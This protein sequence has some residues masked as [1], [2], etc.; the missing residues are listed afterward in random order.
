M[1]CYTP[2][3]EVSHVNQVPPRIITFG[4][5]GT[6]RGVSNPHRWLPSLNVAIPR[7]SVFCT[8]RHYRSVGAETP[9]LTSISTAHPMTA[10][11]TALGGATSPRA[12][13]ITPCLSTSTEGLQK[14]RL[15]TRTTW[16]AM[17]TTLRTGHWPSSLSPAT[18]WTTRC[19]W[20]IYSCQ[21][22]GNNAAHPS[23]LA[24]TFVLHMMTIVGL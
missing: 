14:I 6:H 5:P 18:I 3:I 17:L 4:V 21:F 1:L 23:L 15:T 2:Y 10:P 19:F 13:A 7:S 20:V 22:F 9:R 12:A 11:W 8:A 24:K 16:G